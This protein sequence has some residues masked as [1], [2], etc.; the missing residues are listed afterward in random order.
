MLLESLRK[1]NK[2]AREFHQEIVNEGLVG[3]G[4]SFLIQKAEDFF[5]KSV[6]IFEYVQKLNSIKQ[7][8]G[9]S[10]EDWYARVL[11]IQQ[12]AISSKEGESADSAYT[13]RSLAMETFTNGLADSHL[14]W[15]LMKMETDP[16]KYTLRELLHATIKMPQSLENHRSLDQSK[17]RRKLGVIL[18]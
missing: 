13:M 12:D 9:E 18:K 8:K 15:E 17:R 14:R 11:R 4:Y 1:G 10:L 5:T 2:K 16:S 7:H 3:R 6:S